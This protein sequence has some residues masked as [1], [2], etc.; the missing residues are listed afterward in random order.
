[1]VKDV[2]TKDGKSLPRNSLFSN[3]LE[4]GVWAVVGPVYMMTLFPITVVVQV[5]KQ[6]LKKKKVLRNRPAEGV[7]RIELRGGIKKHADRK[8]DVVLFGSTGFTGQLAAK[9]MAKQYK[10]S[11]VKWAIAG[12][13]AD[14]LEKVKQEIGADVPI[15]I[16]DTS[17]PD[18]LH[19]LVSD[20]KA[21][22]TTAGPFNQYG[23]EVVKFCANYGTHYSDIT[24]EADWVREMIDRFDG[25]AKETGARIVSFCGHDC[26]PWDL[27]TLATAAELKKRTNT[28]LKAITIHDR[29]RAAPSG[30]T[31]ATVFSIIFATEKYVPALKHDPLTDVEGQESGAKT[32]NKNVKLVSYSRFQKVWMTPFVMAGVNALSVKRS[33]AVNKYG[34][35]MEYKEGN[36]VPSF[37]AAMCAMCQMV[38]MGAVVAF[39]PLLSLVR[40]YV[41]PKPGQGPS[42]QSMDNGWLHLSAVAEGEDGSNVEADM[43]FNTDAGYRDTARMVVESGLTLAL[44]DE[45]KLPN[46]PGVLTP[47]CG[48]GQPLLDRLCATGTTFE[49]LN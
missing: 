47:G 10:D 12:R 32:V 48:C 25:I 22:V 31:L 40:K 29:V 20:T 35:R 33:N 30:G 16:A 46:G 27:M 3:L 28:D 14:A 2:W 11:N 43:Y 42:V 7:D 13:R 4:L 34:T 5:V 1:M 21:I 36:V 45:A 18:T 39:P 44:T 24:G 38:C 37:F 26:I 8:Y 9:Y 23:T 6:L 17:K 19:A 49:I 41:L 15:I